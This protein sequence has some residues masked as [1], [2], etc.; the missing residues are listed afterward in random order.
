[1]S[2]LAP[3]F[4]VGFLAVGLPILFHLIRRTT[5]ERKTFSSLMFLI[6]SPPRLTQRN[7]IEHLL[8]LLL[9]CLAICCLAF[10]FARPFLREAIAPPAGSSG[11]RIMLL[12]DASASMRRANLWSDARVKVD[13]ILR[14]T[15]PADQVALFTFDRQLKPLFT[16]DQWTA[17]PLADR[18]PLLA[19]KLVETSPGWGS[20][21]LGNALIQT[22]EILAEFGGKAPAEPGRIEV[23]TDL[24]EGSHL[25]QLQGYEWPKGIEV[26][27][28][29][30][31][32]R[33]TGNASLQL[34]SDTEDS[35]T[36]SAQTVRV[37]ASNAAGAKR[38]QFKIGWARSEK[39]DFVGKPIDVYVPAGQSRILALPTSSTES[40]DRILL[41]GDDEEFD[42]VVFAIPPETLRLNVVYIGAD[43]ETD[44][45]QPLYFLK[46]AFQET[47]YQ[48][49]QVS[50]HHSGELLPAPEVQA[51]RLFVLTAPLSVESTAAMRDQAMAGKTVLVVP[52]T[53]D[54]RAT[55]RGMLKFDNLKLEEVRPSNYAMLAEMDFRHPIFASFADPRFSDF[56]KIHFW[57]YYRLDP[58]GLAGAR[59]LASFDSG[60]PSL[61]EVPT[62][63]GR[64]LILT[65]GWQPE[66]SQLALSSKF[67]PLLYSILESSG[68]PAPLP[69]QY[70]V[71]DV[72]LL[73]EFG[74]AAQSPMTV[75]LP[76][77]TQLALGP[78]DTNF[79]RTDIPGVYTLSTKESA[80]QFVVNLDPSESRT[81]P[82]P[83]DELE[84]LGVPVLQKTTEVRLQDAERKTR[85][86]NAE[87][88]NRQ[89]LWRWF[90]AGTLAVLL[91]ETW[92]AGRTARR[93]LEPVNISPG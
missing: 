72:V 65:S 66:C 17:T 57:K 34:V 60:D 30:L 75:R 28:E 41:Q 88:E 9:R 79:S 53:I 22:A 61:V 58:T 33:G 56:T 19:R 25:E 3:L 87:L 43:S 5:R 13:S 49:V 29:V 23:I 36:K 21:Q 47:R 55:L 52:S 81:A 4:L 11:K 73:A 59:V 48:S 40:P 1:M 64:I 6:P 83:L 14:K 8:L 10:G 42:N 46:R 68:V 2:F 71:G 85:F 92:L 86:Q 90:I 26:S 18:G 84:R 32:P 44:S 63:K 89:K 35:N 37:R 67:V 76:D 24:Q 62:G 82:L 12:V 45:K 38:E 51:S 31:K 70:R 91:I 93:A 80:R 16:F 54:M 74:I 77:A 20:T 50:A 78:A 69:A 39:G 15:T 27:I 7:R